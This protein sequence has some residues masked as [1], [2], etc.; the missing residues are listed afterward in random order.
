MFDFAYVIFFLSWGR[1][2]LSRKFEII[3][4]PVSLL[5]LELYIH[6]FVQLVSD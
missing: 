2:R 3:S 1:D 5:Y 4:S 6:S